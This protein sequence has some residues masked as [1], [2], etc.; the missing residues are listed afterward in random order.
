[1]KLFIKILLVSLL[2]ASCSKKI[3][4]T[5]DIQKEYKFPE[6]R[7][8]KVQ[9][10][11]SKQIVLFKIKQE[12]DAVITDGKVLL[13]HK[14]DVEK[15]IIKK[16]TPCILEEVIDENK[17]L[18]SFEAVDGRVLLFGNTGSGYYSI[19]AKNWKGGT[20][21]IEYANKTY[22]TTDGDAFL[23]IKAKNLKQ[24]KGKQRTVKGRRI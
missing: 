2:F 8:K 14:K 12:G 10:Y 6:A 9:F 20:G 17:F 24:L 23:N 4:F 3:A 7:L 21:A 19:M 15:I 22:V 11:T 13:K 18:F 5:S 16:N 1:M